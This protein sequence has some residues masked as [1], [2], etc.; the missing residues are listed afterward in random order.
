MKLNKKTKLALISSISL[1]ASL[2]PAVSIGITQQPTKAID[3]ANT[4]ITQDNNSSSEFIANKN[5]ASKNYPGIFDPTKTDPSKLDSWEVMK[6]I[7]QWGK[8]TANIVRQTPTHV[9]IGVNL[10][11]N[12]GLF[13]N[14]GI[15]AEY[16]KTGQDFT[17]TNTRHRYAEK[18]KFGPIN[19][20]TPKDVVNG[21]SEFTIPKTNED[22]VVK[23]ALGVIYEKGE[24]QNYYGVSV[25]TPEIV[26]PKM[27]PT[28]IDFKFTNSDNVANISTSIVNNKMGNG[29]VT[30]Y[31]ILRRE[32][33]KN[34]DWK[35]VRKVTKFGSE[36]MNYQIIKDSTQWEYYVAATVTHKDNELYKDTIVSGIF[37]VGQKTTISSPDFSFDDRYKDRMLVDIKTTDKKDSQY[38][39]QYAVRNTYSKD[40]KITWWIEK[41]YDMNKNSGISKLGYNSAEVKSS[42][43]LNLSEKNNYSFSREDR[44]YRL[45]LGIRYS[46]FNEGFG[47][48]V[49]ETCYTD[50]VTIDKK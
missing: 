34:D 48:N 33:N 37:R 30:E 13:L 11:T 12:G 23:Y 32:I 50:F 42:Q 41:T 21:Y 25:W 19:Q 10:N 36:G 17:Y 7:K 31:S 3:N 4:N 14:G 9:T 15:V 2:I 16:Q 44:S 49:T 43:Q 5:D 6:W 18:T 35:Y 28:K 8:F 47:K 22:R 1:T 20:F 27:A 45:R 29:L 26:I 39:V 24:Y 40:I 46:T 38:I